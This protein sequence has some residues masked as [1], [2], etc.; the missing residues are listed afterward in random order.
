MPLALKLG[1][2]FGWLRGS[3]NGHQS[4]DLSVIDK[5]Q[6][7]KFWQGE[8]LHK[9]QMRPATMKISNFCCLKILQTG[10]NTEFSKNIP[11]REYLGCVLLM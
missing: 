7:L 8:P 2:Y 9:I 10:S 6:H 4:L 5:Q 1:C 3:G 11:C